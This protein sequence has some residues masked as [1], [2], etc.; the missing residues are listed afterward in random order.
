[1]KKKIIYINLLQK[2]TT[3]SILNLKTYKI[4]SLKYILN[5]KY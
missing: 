4:V 2:Y 3:F 5:K 1:M